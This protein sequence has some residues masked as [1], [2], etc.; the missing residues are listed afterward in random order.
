MLAYRREHGIIDQ[1]LFSALNISATF[2]PS[3]ITQS[4]ISFLPLHCEL[5]AASSGIWGS[6]PCYFS[7]TMQ[8]PRNGPPSKYF[9]QQ[10]LDLCLGG[11][12]WQRLQQF[13]SDQFML[14][15]EFDW[16]TYV[17]F[18]RSCSWWGRS[19]PSSDEHLE[20]LDGTKMVL[21]SSFSSDDDILGLHYIAKFGDDQY[22][23][24][25]PCSH[26]K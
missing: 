25:V 13:L 26:P 1:V 5:S 18:K 22:R 8:Q 20:L 23:A 9:L 12:C 3:P 24:S 14:R 11:C 10:L 21:F 16:C 7:C 6:T 19:S 15:M 4:I 2:K 17:H